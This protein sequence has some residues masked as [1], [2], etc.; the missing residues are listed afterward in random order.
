MRPTIAA[1]AELLDQDVCRA[2]PSKGAAG[3]VR[4]AK[5]EAD[6]GRADVGYVCTLEEFRTQWPLR[7]VESVAVAV[8][9]GTDLQ[10]VEVGSQGAPTQVLLVSCDSAGELLDLLGDALVRYDEWERR[11]LVAA[12]EAR[13]PGDVLAIGAEL[14]TNPIA[15]FDPGATLIARAGEVPED[16]S[17]TM[18]KSV[19]EKGFSPNEIYTEA[20]R[21]E[22]A[23]RLASG[24]E[25]YLLRPARDTKPIL[26]P[27]SS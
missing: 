13:S 24:A 1:I 20:E 27:S 22:Y 17:E 12:A 8:P 21:R 5:L 4:F 15:L 10:A 7:H 23:R 6:S 16:T 14:L 2:L 11:M 25:H 19:F 9:A 26:L 3:L 18:W